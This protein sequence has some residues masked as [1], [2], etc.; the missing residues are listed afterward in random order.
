MPAD[1]MP[2]LTSIQG[3]A[4]TLMPRPHM[5]NTRMAVYGC[6]GIQIQARRLRGE[7]TY[8][9]AIFPGLGHLLHVQQYF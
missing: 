4:H 7:R 1:G 3:T 9:S 6:V 5:L 8:L 2:N